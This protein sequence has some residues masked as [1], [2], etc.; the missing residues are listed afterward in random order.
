MENRRVVAAAAAF[1]LAGFSTSSCSSLDKTVKFSANTWSYSELDNFMEEL[2][3][4][5]SNMN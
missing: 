4:P 5:I 3:W 1:H 2:A